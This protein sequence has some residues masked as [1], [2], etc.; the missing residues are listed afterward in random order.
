MRAKM[1]KIPANAVTLV[2]LPLPPIYISE[3]AGLNLRNL[4]RF[5]CTGDVLPAQQN[6]PEVTNNETRHPHLRSDRCRRRSRR[7]SRYA[8]DRARHRKPPVGHRQ[9]PDSDVRT[10]YLPR[11]AR[12]RPINTR[13]HEGRLN[14][15]VFY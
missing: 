1:R 4:L 7:R 11:P 8:Q 5:W 10:L 14:P 13:G 6:P 15:F 3:F 12:F 2:T 9:L